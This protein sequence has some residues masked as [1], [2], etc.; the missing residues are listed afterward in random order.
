MWVCQETFTCIDFAGPR[1]DS[2]AKPAK[3][4]ARTLFK[5]MIRYADWTE[6]KSH[7][8]RIDF[9]AMEDLL[10]PRW[11]FSDPADPQFRESN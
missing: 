9:S 1:R 3:V 8:N 6:L 11:P 7:Q 4:I 2:S 5:E 10:L